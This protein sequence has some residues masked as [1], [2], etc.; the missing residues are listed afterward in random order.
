MAYR[1]GRGNFENIG[2]VHCF[3]VVMVS[4]LCSYAETYETVEFKCAIYCMQ[5]YFNKTL[6]I[7]NTCFVPQTWKVPSIQIRK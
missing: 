7:S 4:Q 1:E 3:L 6:K 2:Y 5:L